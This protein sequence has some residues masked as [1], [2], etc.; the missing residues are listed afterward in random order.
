[1]FT[2]KNRT[3]LRES[4]H[5]PSQ[6]LDE[7]WETIKVEANQLM[8]DL[9]ETYDDMMQALRQ[10]VERRRQRRQKPVVRFVRRNPWLPIVAGLGAITVLVIAAKS[11]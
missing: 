11:R 4:M 3:S 9:Q 5:Q 10:V 6:A 7:S 8:T 1:M 2:N